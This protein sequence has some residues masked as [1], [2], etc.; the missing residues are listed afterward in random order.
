MANHRLQSRQM[1]LH[2]E[3][4]D[5]QNAL[6]EQLN[7]DRPDIHIGAD[8]TKMATICAKAEK[9]ICTR[10]AVH[11]LPAGTNLL[12]AVNTLLQQMQTLSAE[13]HEWTSH[14]TMASQPRLI[15]LK[16]MARRPRG[17]D[18]TPDHPLSHMY[19]PNLLSYPDVW[20]AFIWGFHA[21][22]QIIFRE[23]YIELIEFHTTISFQDATE[24]QLNSMQRA[25]SLIE[26]LA[27]SIIC[28]FS[29]LMG[30]TNAVGEVT[31]LPEQGLMAG[32]CL[33][34]FAMQVI[35]K[36]KYS[37]PEHKDTAEAVLRW[38]SAS[39]VLD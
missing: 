18:Y 2:E 21:A 25:R 16:T 37:L 19:C 26:G 22:C 3:P 31:D 13:I 36:A 8:A 27:A 38:M 12:Q 14:L 15:D 1:L 9:L 30:F 35:Q 11:S 17:S 10:R 32:R 33:A 39:Y 24:D 4:D 34:L 6:L 7:L 28:S 29:T 20:L 5:M 23:M